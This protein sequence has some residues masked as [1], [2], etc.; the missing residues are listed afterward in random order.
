MPTFV[1]SYCLA[2]QPLTSSKKARSDSHGDLMPI[3]VWRI[4]TQ[5]EGVTDSNIDCL[6][7]LHLELPL[8]RGMGETHFCVPIQDK[9]L[10]LQEYAL[11]RMAGIIDSN[12]L[13]AEILSA[14]C[15]V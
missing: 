13:S 1:R 2:A 12:I 3:P 14:L 4:T 5:I 6:N 10:R 11:S 8:L 15:G 9:L 7:C